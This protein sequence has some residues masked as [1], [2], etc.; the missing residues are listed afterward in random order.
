MEGH[1]TAELGR[2]TLSTWSTGGPGKVADA[3]LRRV[4]MMEVRIVC[5]LGRWEWQKEGY[6]LIQQVVC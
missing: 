6:F 3:T 2:D 4:P 1:C 5:H